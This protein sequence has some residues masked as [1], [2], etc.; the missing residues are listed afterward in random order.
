MRPVVLR[1]LAATPFLSTL[2]GCSRG[3]VGA[4]GAA[5]PA[6][7]PRR[8]WASYPQPASPRPRSGHDHS[9]K[10]HRDSAADFFWHCE[11]LC[12]LQ[13]SVPLP[14]MRASLRE[15]LLDFNADHLRGV[16]WAPLLSTLCPSSVSRVSSSQG[17]ARR[18]L[19]EIKFTAV[20]FL[21]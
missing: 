10:L 2:R 6:G 8:V 3:V 16:E 18:V 13:D 19:T 12:V 11:D 15:G 20:V 17:L 9:V 21:R 1:L 4:R 7:A 14:A 5:R